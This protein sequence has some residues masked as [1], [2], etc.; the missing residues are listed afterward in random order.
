MESDNLD[1]NE[2]TEQIDEYEKTIKYDKLANEAPR[3]KA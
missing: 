2:L 3:N 1:F